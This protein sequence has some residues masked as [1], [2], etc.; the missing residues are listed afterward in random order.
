MFHFLQ[1]V[2]GLFIFSGVTYALTINNGLSLSNPENL[3]TPYPSLPNSIN[4]NESLHTD[5]TAHCH[6]VDAPDIHIF[7][8]SDCQKLAKATC[9]SIGVTQP[10]RFMRDKWFWTEL[11][12][13]AVGY[14]IPSGAYLP[15]R[16]SCSVILEEIIS[17]CIWASDFNAGSNNVLLLPAIMEE[18]GIPLDWHHPMYL[19]SP[20]KLPN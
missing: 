13:C 6:H 15:S 20:W 11:D 10:H 16:S 17:K 4:V 1:N 18:D 7:V 19:I 2:L 3:N 14:F 8:P 12:G 9:I 5:F